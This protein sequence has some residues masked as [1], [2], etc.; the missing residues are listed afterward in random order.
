MWRTRRDMLRGREP[1]GHETRNM[2]NIQ[3]IISIL[4]AAIASSD[5][6]EQENAL[7]AG[8]EWSMKMMTSNPRPDD[9]QIMEAKLEVLAKLLHIE[10]A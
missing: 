5:V 6:K 4:D 8:M 1:S 2:S 9:I 7:R 3:N 10:P